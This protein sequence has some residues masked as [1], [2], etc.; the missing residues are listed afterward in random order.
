ME[1]PDFVDDT[2]TMNSAANNNILNNKVER[3]FQVYTVHKLHI[4]QAQ[5]TVGCSDKAAKFL[6]RLK[7]EIKC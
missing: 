3:R 7:Y 2:I 5:S 1:D 4:H 6:E